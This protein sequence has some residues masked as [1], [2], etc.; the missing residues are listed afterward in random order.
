MPQGIPDDD[1]DDYGAQAATA[2][3]LGAVSCNQCPEKIVH[4]MVFTSFS[5]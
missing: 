3:L 1:K 4:V 2:Q 5:K